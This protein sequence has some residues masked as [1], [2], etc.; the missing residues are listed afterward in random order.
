MVECSIYGPQQD[1]KPI[2]FLA[3]ATATLC[4]L[5]GAAFA[6]RLES[7]E[8]LPAGEPMARSRGGESP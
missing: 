2:A 8:S 6:D 4:R 7:G 3:V 5:A 1:F